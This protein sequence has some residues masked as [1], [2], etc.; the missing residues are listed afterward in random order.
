[1]DA[2]SDQIGGE[3]SNIK[4]TTTFLKHVFLFDDD[5]KAELLNILQYSSL[6]V[7]PVLILNKIVKKYIPE[8]DETKG[9]I[10]LVVEVLAQLFIMLIGVFYVHRLVTFLPT[11]SG[12]AYEPLIL[13]H[14]IL[15]FLIIILSL[16]TK[17]GEKTNILLERAFDLWNGERNLEEEEREGMQNKKNSK[18]QPPVVPN[19]RTSNPFPQQEAMTMK[20]EPSQVNYD[21]MHGQT[22]NSL[23]NA[24]GPGSGY[25]PEHNELMAA[26]EALGGSAFGS[27][28]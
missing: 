24:S 3:T 19:G 9:S 23:M 20:N 18:K 8:V 25:Y 21:S 4:R 10:E 1:M 28:F 2:L 12:V 7:V 15:V 17:M 22:Q 11:Y 27:M 14:V 6:S 26:N 5:T 13:T 16:Q